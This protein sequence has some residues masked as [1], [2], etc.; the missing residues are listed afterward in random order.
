MKETNITRLSGLGQSVWLDH[1][2]RPLIDTGRLTALIEEGLRG[3]TSNPAI[4]DKAI[5]SSSDYDEAI[6]ALSKNGKTAFEIYDE[7]TIG[8]VR[9][10]LDAFRPVYDRTDGLDGY[11]SL[12]VDPKLAFNME[13][14]IEEARRLWKKVA[15]PNLMLKV[16]ATEEGFQAVEE[17]IAS[18]MNVNITLIFYL[19]QYIKSAGAYIKGVERLVK[20]GGDASRIRSVAS[21]FVSRIDSSIDKMLG[22]ISTAGTLKGKAAVANSHRIY[23][24]YLRI[25]SS[26]RFQALKER[27][28]NV[29]RALWASTSTKDPEYSDIKYVTELIGKDSVNT[30]PDNT[31]G[32]FLDHGVVEEAL[33]ADANAAH[34]VIRSLKDN[35]IDIDEV[36]KKLL[37][38]GIEA[39]V[40][41]FDS[42][43]GSIENKSERLC[44][45]KRD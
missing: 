40:N 20:S 5:S 11:V 39:F 28:A 22:G 14:T 30:L 4:F 10:A 21:V 27:G 36:C 45:A 26:A 19:E 38:D 32:A 17:I 23:A 24:E 34:S 15:R 9:D 35:G 43:I 25:F 29:Q 31:L 42:L 33:T 37:K 8:D 41:A 18:G 44:G 6:A 16:P 3:I 2:S 1:I 7:L 13:G 12:E